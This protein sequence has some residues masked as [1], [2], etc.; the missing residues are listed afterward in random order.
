[1]AVAVACVIP[2]LWHIVQGGRYQRQAGEHFNP[3]LYANLET[4]GD[5][6]HYIGSSPWA[7]NNRSEAAGGGHAHAGLMVYQGASWP[8][9][10][11][12]LTFMNNI[13]GAR[14]NVD[15]LEPQGSGYVGR[16]ADDFLDFNDPASQVINL[17]YDQ[18]GSVYLIDWYD[19]EQCHVNNP[20]VPDRGNGRIF[21][22]V[23]GDTPTTRVD[24]QALSD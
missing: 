3:H 7:G 21:K 15:V 20:D 12:G 10:Y 18:D 9:R 4:I 16:H 23:Y 6:L 22:I 13:H 8:D 17:Q 1:H 2:H 14:I 24:V 11:R 5:H 19:Q